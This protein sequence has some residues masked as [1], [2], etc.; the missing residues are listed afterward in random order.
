MPYL[1]FMQG[2]ES[3]KNENFDFDISEVDEEI[4][5]DE[6]VSTSLLINVNFS[7]VMPNDMLMSTK[8]VTSKGRV[9]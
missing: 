9:F 8:N 1:A 5:S 4:E 6:S 2:M 7:A 3:A